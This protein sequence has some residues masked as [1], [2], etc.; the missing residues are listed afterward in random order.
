MTSSAQPATH[1]LP[2]WRAT[3]AACEVAPPRAVRMPCATAMPW[4]SSGEVSTRTST[5]CSPRPTH[6]T[7]VSALKTARPDRRARRGVQALGDAGRLGE[8]GRVELV[9]QQLVDV[10]GLDPGDRLF[11]GDRA[12]VHHVDRDPHGGG[13]GPLGRARLEHVEPAALDRE[14]EVLDVAVVLL[15]LLPD[16]LE[17]GVDRGHVGRHLGDLRR[18]PDAGH[19]VLALGVGQVLAVEDLLAGVRV[20]RERDARAR[21]VAHVAEDHRHDVDRGPEVVRRCSG[22]CGSRARACRTTRRRRP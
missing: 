10:G 7:A 3:T 14:L 6:S 2:I 17:L 8:A 18:G 4:K 1:G 21:V 16:A 9:A 13:R 11:L 15:E 5:T 19:D 20:A 22:S 12:F